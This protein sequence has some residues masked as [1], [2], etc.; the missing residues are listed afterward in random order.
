MSVLSGEALFYWFLCLGPFLPFLLLTLAYKRL[1]ES[2]ASAMQR[3]LADQPEREAY[4]AFG[5]GEQRRTF[6]AYYHW[7]AYASALIPVALVTTGLTAAGLIKLGVPLWPLPAEFQAQ[8]RDIPRLALAG[9]GGGYLFAMYDA[10]ARYRTVDF[11]PASLHLMWLRLPVAALFAPVL[12]KPFSEE[13]GLAVALAVGAFPLRD[14]WS[15]VRSKVD[16]PSSQGPVE[17]PTLQLLQGMSGEIR[18]RL[19]DESIDSVGQLAFTD[20]VGLLFRSNLE[21]NVL[22]DLIDQA[23]WV[24]YV[25]E[26]IADV[27]PLGV[28]SAIEMASIDDRLHNGTPEEKENARRMVTLLAT[29]LGRSEDAIL[30]LGYQL[31]NDPLVQFL[32]G[33]WAPGLETEEEEGTGLLGA[34]PGEGGMP[35]L[36]VKER[37]RTDLAETG[38]PLQKDLP[39]S[40]SGAEQ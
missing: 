19:R 40:D 9:A 33:Q 39:D 25:G 2:K 18:D 22:L 27:R 21:W 8:V 13:L 11:Y 17:A 16:V 20:P 35:P 3:L 34:S 10:V 38:P 29:T 1:L 32:W 7:F 36:E 28:R 31:N 15:Y 24:N 4:E 6:T 37:A 14:L 26:R 5:P 12:S 30:N 23:I